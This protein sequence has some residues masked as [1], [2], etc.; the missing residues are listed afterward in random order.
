MDLSIMASGEVFP[1]YLHSLRKK[2]NL[3]KNSTRML[4]A[5]VVLSMLIPNGVAIAHPAAS[6]ES[7]YT[8]L[9]FGFS[10]RSVETA[11]Q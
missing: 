5:L 6:V 11:Y 9:P 3:R 4:H 8:D 7:E 2:L 1:S 10:P